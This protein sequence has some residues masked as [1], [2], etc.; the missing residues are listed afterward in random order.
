MTAHFAQA[1]LAISPEHAPSLRLI[2][3]LEQTMSFG[4][5]AMMMIGR[6]PSHA[7]DFSLL[8]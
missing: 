6:A 7:A 3:Q 4:C 2:F 5:Y 1:S 8:R